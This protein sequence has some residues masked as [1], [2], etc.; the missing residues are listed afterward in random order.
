[1]DLCDD[2]QTAQITAILEVPGVHKEDLSLHIE[3]N[4]LTVRGQR[5][6]IVLTDTSGD[7]SDRDLALHTSNTTELTNDKQSVRELRYGEFRRHISL[8]SGTQVYI[9]HVPTDSDVTN[10]SRS[11]PTYLLHYETAC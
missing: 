7:S 11:H 6:P 2:P 3:G 4:S 1:M 10:V 5:R 8:P 9:V